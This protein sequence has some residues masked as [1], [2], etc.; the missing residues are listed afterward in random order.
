VSAEESD[1][2]WCKC[3]REIFR[4]IGTAII[5]GPFPWA[6][7]D[8]GSPPPLLCEKVVTWFCDMQCAGNHG[9]YGSS[10]PGESVAS[11]P[12]SAVNKSPIQKEG[13]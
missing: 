7:D 4:P 2:V 3:G 10:V 11:N 6:V 1:R 12:V 5:S 9:A 13:A 8:N